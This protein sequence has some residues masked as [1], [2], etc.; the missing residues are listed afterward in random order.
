MDLL[1]DTSNVTFE[2]ATNPGPKLDPSGKQKFDRDTKLPMWTVQ[3]Y[4]LD[5]RGG[6]VINVTVVNEVKPQVAVREQVVPVRLVAL[7]W[8]TER[9]GK[10]RSGVAFKAF[11]LKSA[12]VPAG[13]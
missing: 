1:V 5:A 4:A 6:E 10:V 3:L 2:V 11:E 7:P 8:V 9:E 13:K 12:L